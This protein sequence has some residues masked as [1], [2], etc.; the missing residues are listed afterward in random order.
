MKKR[1]G[2]KIF[3]TIVA[4][5][6]VVI[7]LAAG[8]MLAYIVSQ[9]N[10]V[11]VEIDDVN[12]SLA[13]QPMTLRERLRFED[14]GSM[15]FT[16]DENDVWWFISQKQG[17]DF[18]EKLAAA[19]AEYHLSYDGIGLTLGGDEC[20]G[21]LKCHLAFIPVNVRVS[22][23]IQYDGNSITAA[24]AAIE[25]L[26]R[27]FSTE[28]LLEK[29]GADLSEPLFSYEPASSFLSQIRSITV[30]EGTLTV[31]GPMETRSVSTVDLT[32]VQ[33]AYSRL[34]FEDFSFAGPVV[35][36]YDQDPAVC[37]ASLLP[38]LQ[39]D[40]SVYGEYLEQLFA[41]MPAFEIPALA[42][43]SINH[44]FFDRWYGE[45]DLSAYSSKSTQHDNDF[46]VAQRFVQSALGRL[47]TAYK[48]GELK[49]RSSQFTL[50]GKPFTFEALY[51]DEYTYYSRMIPME[52]GRL[53]L[54]GGGA[55][56]DGI[57]L[58]STA[59]SASQFSAEVKRSSI[60]GLGILM[61]GADGYPYMLHLKWNP[62]MSYYDYAAEIVSEADFSTMMNTDVIPVWV[63]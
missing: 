1:S 32:E 25:T 56:K 14:D 58:S 45:M 38:A 37:Y 8:G 34:M 47:Y 36:S 39:K 5:L 6:L 10:K 13:A 59:D 33:L 23:R 7:L 22:L 19:L 17:A 57:A 60:Y 28:Y 35:A 62:A 49:I 20:F 15:H 24:A 61:R 46:M 51:G 52:S 41:M 3:L 27:T 54:V 18:E 31:S 53:C 4:A 63:P 50:S 16:L 42:N 40:A 44:G 30:G 43:R 9:M 2:A 11:P 21:Y 12:A 55:K 26:G 48:K 29:F